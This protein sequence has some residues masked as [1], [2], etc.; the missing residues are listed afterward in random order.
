M[1]SQVDHRTRGRPRWA[2]LLSREK[3][4][5]I[6]RRLIR[7]EGGRGDRAGSCGARA[8]GGSWFGNRTRT[9][10]RRRAQ[11][12]VARRAQ[13]WI[14]RRTQTGVTRRSQTGIAGRVKTGPASCHGWLFAVRV[15][16]RVTSR[17]LRRRRGE[18]R[19]VS[20]G[21]G[22][23][24]GWSRRRRLL[25]LGSRG[26]SRLPRRRSLLPPGLR[27]DPTRLAGVV[28]VRAALLGRRA[29]GEIGHEADPPANCDAARSGVQTQ[30]LRRP[31]AASSRSFRAASDTRAA[32]PTFRTSPPETPPN[33]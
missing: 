12:G 22:R 28:I 9:R 11:A 14:C 4:G 17:R 5:E 30:R 18:R 19:R 10:V 3:A 32:R 23:R 31:T 25:R 2:G 7:A 20:F 13:T 6:T 33:D 29:W 27:P 1:T 8:T 21:P 26:T 15:M 16:S 24:L